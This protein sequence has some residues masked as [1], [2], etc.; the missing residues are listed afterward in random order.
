MIKARQSRPPQ[1]SCWRKLVWCLC[2]A[3]GLLGLA[4]L[5]RYTINGINYGEEEFEYRH[6]VTDVYFQS[7][8]ADHRR[9]AEG[10]LGDGG[11]PDSA[12]GCNTVH[13]KMT[14]LRL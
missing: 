11:L 5:A 12:A 7:Y 13:A 10:P 1:L 14:D 6:V 4:F 8:Y 9:L 2:G 3:V